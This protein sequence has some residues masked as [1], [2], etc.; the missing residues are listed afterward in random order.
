[1]KFKFK[2]FTSRTNS[3]RG[4]SLVYGEKYLGSRFGGALD[5]TASY[6]RFTE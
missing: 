5:R 1:V 4:S 6:T 3:I 2:E